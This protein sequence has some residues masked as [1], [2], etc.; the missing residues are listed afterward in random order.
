MD[1]LCL[2]RNAGDFD[3]LGVGGIEVAEIKGRVNDLMAGGHGVV[4]R[5]IWIRIRE[6]RGPVLAFD[7]SRPV[8]LTVSGAGADAVAEIL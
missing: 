3:L 4:H 2:R 7:V 5:Y 1:P 8:G 6:I